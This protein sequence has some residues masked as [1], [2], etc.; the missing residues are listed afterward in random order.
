METLQKSAINCKNIETL[1]IPQGDHNE[2]WTIDPLAY[3]AKIKEF[4][5]KY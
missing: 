4:F 2:N 1:E 3:F 5:T